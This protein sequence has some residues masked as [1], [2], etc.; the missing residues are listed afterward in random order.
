MA[1]DGRR[2]IPELV[3]LL[4]GSAVTDSYGKGAS[5]EIGGLPF[6]SWRH[7]GAS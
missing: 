4:D 5:V 6:D 3:Q 2:L 7:G 1:A